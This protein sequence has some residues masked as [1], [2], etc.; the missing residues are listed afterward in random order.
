MGGEDAQDIVFDKGIPYLYGEKS[1]ER[2]LANVGEFKKTK[3][4][5]MPKMFFRKKI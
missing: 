1:I 4:G 3:V 5:E 2:F